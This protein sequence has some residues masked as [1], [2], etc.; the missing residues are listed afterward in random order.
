MAR[1]T[2]AAPMFFT[3]CDNYVDGGVLANNPCECGLTEIQNFARQK[4][5]K[6]SISVIISVGTGIYPAEVLG[7]VDAQKF[8]FFGKHWLKMN[9][10]MKRAQNL[11]LLLSNAVSL[12]FAILLFSICLSEIIIIAVSLS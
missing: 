10:L 6:V 3:E 8:L 7:K 9:S 4:E 12:M 5:D 11:M 2:S 1:Y